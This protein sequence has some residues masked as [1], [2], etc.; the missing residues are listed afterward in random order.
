M[1]DETLLL[2][3]DFATTVADAEAGDYSHVHAECCDLTA[4]PFHLAFWRF[5]TWRGP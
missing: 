3:A 5:P 1:A 2:P 4:V